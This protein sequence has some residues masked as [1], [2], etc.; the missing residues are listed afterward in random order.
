M[1]NFKLIIIALLGFGGI[2]GV[3]VFAGFINLDDKAVNSGP[4]GTVILWGT[5]P[6]RIVNPLLEE[7]NKDKSYKVRY[8]SKN[9]QN[10][11]QDLLEAMAIGKGPDLLLLP[12][13]LTLKYQ[14]KLY[15][16]PYA[17]YPLINFKNT[18]AAASEVFLSSKGVSALPLTIDPMVMYYNRT[19]LDSNNVIYPPVYWDEF[20]EFVNIFNKKDES[21][22][23]TQSAFALGQFSNVSHAKDILLTLFM[24]TGS[25][26]V[27]EQN[28]FFRADLDNFRKSQT[29]TASSLDF[30]TS[31][32]NPLKPNYSWNKSLPMSIDAFSKEDLA[33][34]FGFA[35]DLRTLLNKNPNQDFQ[36]ATMPQIRNTNNKVTS[37]RVTGIAIS[38]FSKNLSTS[39][40]AAVALTDSDFALKY[41][42]AQLIPPAR[43]DLLARA[44]SDSYFPV[45]YSSS[46]FARSW[47]DPSSPD[48]SNIFRLMV[49]EVLSNARKPEEA[50]LNANNRLN[51]LIFN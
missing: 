42:N 32:S 26:I 3:F 27:S 30:Y 31:F 15:T 28:G 8:V 12:D 23:I 33:F 19:M 37:S 36:V 24:Q 10:F 41:S 9:P 46:L 50:I 25:P 1:N 49:E 43:R 2:L 21:Q 7:F 16:I 20:Y 18:F 17:S 11:D 13:N 47:L 6:V 39:L 38:S 48:S 5:T 14:N 44:R 40:A 34:Y 22:Q 35:S 45:F 29:N 4:T 51:T